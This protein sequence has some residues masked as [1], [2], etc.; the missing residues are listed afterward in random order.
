MGARERAG[1]TQTGLAALI[2]VTQASISAWERGAAP[3][4]TQHLQPLATALSVRVEDLAVEV[5]I[6]FCPRYT[7]DLL[8]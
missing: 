6:F 2:G 4:H 8:K 1:F 5:A 7:A 3:P